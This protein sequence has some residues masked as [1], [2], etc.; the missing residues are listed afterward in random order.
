MKLLSLDH[1]A[2]RWQSWASNLS[3]TLGCSLF[4]KTGVVA[5]LFE[6]GVTGFLMHV[7]MWVAGQSEGIQEIEEDSAREFSEVQWCSVTQVSLSVGQWGW[8]RLWQL[9]LHLS[10]C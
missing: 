7:Y 5:A 9:S 2:S 8:G 1:S 3:L 6:L 4:A 10:T